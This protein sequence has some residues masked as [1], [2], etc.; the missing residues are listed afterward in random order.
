MSTPSSAPSLLLVPQ[1]DAAPK[2]IKIRKSRGKWTPEEDEAL[3]CAVMQNGAKNWKKI[4]EAVPGRTDVQCLHRWQKV[5]NPDLVK[6]P[7]TK[8]EDELLIKLVKEH[9][10]N[11]W[12]EIAKHFKGRIGKQCR[13]R[14]H[15]HL[16][17]EIKKGNWTEEEDRLI[18]EAHERLGNRWAEIAKLLPGRTDNAIKNHWN[19]TMKRQG[20]KRTR[21]ER[22]SEEKSD[23]PLSQPQS[24]S[25][26]PVHSQT[27]SSPLPS[28][29]TANSLLSHSQSSTPGE[30]SHD[31]DYDDEDYVPGGKTSSKTSTLQ[32]QLPQSRKTKNTK[33]TRKKRKMTSRGSDSP[34]KSSGENKR[35]QSAADTSH[36]GDDFH[37]E[38]DMCLKPFIFIRN[39]TPTHPTAINISNAHSFQQQQQRQNQNTTTSLPESTPNVELPLIEIL[40][41]MRYDHNVSVLSSSTSLSTEDNLILHTPVTSTAPSTTA[42]T[43]TTANNN[44]NSHTC[45]IFSED[46]NARHSMLN[47]G[48]ESA[49][50]PIP[51][52]DLNDEPFL[53]SSVLNQS[54]SSLTPRRTPTR[55]SLLAKMKSPPSILR[56][57]ST[58]PTASLTT[59]TPSSPLSSLGNLNS[60]PHVLKTPTSSF[61]SPPSRRSL[62]FASCVSDSVGVRTPSPSKAPLSPSQF[63]LSSPTAF[64]PFKSLN[65]SDTEVTGSH[66]LSPG[67]STRMTSPGRQAHLDCRVQT[68]QNNPSH[69]LSEHNKPNNV[70]IPSLIHELSISETKSNVQQISTNVPVSSPPSSSVSSVSTVQLPVTSLSSSPNLHLPC[71]L[72]TQH[73]T[74]PWQL[75]MGIRFGELGI[76]QQ[77]AIQD[78][79]RKVNRA[80]NSSTSLLSSENISPHSSKALQLLNQTKSDRQTL[81]QQAFSLFANERLD[82]P[83]I[84]SSSSMCP[85]PITSA[86]ETSFI[87]PSSTHAVQPSSSLKPCF[88]TSNHSQH[89]N[90]INIPY[91]KVTHKDNSNS[92]IY[93]SNRSENF[94]SI[95]NDVSTCQSNSKN[96]F[97]ANKE[98]IR[99][100][101]VVPTTSEL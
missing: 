45:T 33:N 26:P 20:Q 36:D 92:A 100:K 22:K 95:T 30:Y 19:S 56:R 10:P 41:N 98:N 48:E 69:E 43:T 64:S 84:G 75:G 71:S 17:P 32:Q 47:V 5:L 53:E 38:D 29:C 65:V 28:S 74:G 9:G 70:T 97:I 85:F 101:I 35:T 49:S 6:G 25:Q 37:H 61:K 79:N 50:V 54:V 1:N 59:S 76:E 73:A 3:R 27:Q 72:Q 7:W 15:N 46:Y 34:G 52:L 13:E 42:T 18:R 2:Q 80:F 23:S 60:T 82:P 93:T 66:Y 86:S 16:N 81:V 89:A 8:E 11:K 31:D 4:A 55:S 90:L 21:K 96:S 83:L 63:L 51:E 77:K 57:R 58:A 88:L 24:Q 94:G 44:H 40:N 91:N 12:S 99:P 39:G 67:T 78:I 68:C 62:I 87:S 14:W